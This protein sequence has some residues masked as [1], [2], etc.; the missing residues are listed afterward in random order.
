MSDVETVTL[1]GEV[2]P[3][4][5]VSRSRRA[6]LAGSA[7]GVG[8]LLNG[9]VKASPALALSSPAAS[10]GAPVTIVSAS[11]SAQELDCRGGIVAYD[12]TET[13]NCTYS[14]SGAVAGVECLITLTRWSD[15]VST[16]IF[17]SNL[18]WANGLQPFFAA[19]A[20][21]CDVIVFRSTDGGVRWQAMPALTNAVPAAAPPPPPVVPGAPT[22][23]AAAAGDGIVA[24]T[25][26]PP[27]SG[28][29]VTSYN[30][31]RGTA[32]G[33]ETL[34]SSAGNATSYTDTTVTNGVTYYYKV[35]ATNAAGE[36]SPSTSA[37]ASPTAVAGTRSLTLP[38][39]AG[40]YAVTPDAASNRISTDIDLRSKL[41]LPTSPPAAV[42]AIVGKWG[43]L[44]SQQQ[45]LMFVDTNGRLNAAT[46]INEQFVI[47]T[48]SVPLGSAATSPLWVRAT[49][50]PNTPTG[51]WTIRFY[52]APDSANSPGP[53]SLLGNDVVSTSGGGAILATGGIDV[54]VG[55][56][57]FGTINNLKGNIHR[58]QIR[59]GVDGPTV[60]DAD[61]TVP[62]GGATTFAGQTGE[63]WTVKGSA[64]I[65]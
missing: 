53:W 35:T 18:L 64:A 29:S 50:Q 23:L 20:G 25:W 5:Q 41:R 62:P 59:N 27:S 49:I 14:M 58:V 46:R 40:S 45:F 19:K 55:S 1:E 63:T 15:G 28:G 61:F 10:P 48:S 44:A 54:E 7:V 56:T 22:N 37:P 12:V 51:G 13:A 36:G 31:Y 2:A 65:A 26:A 9:I 43:N 47:A 21:R 42:G 32:A 52:T 24:M 16:P 11:G 33:Q 17:P 57:S 30:V 60:I 38:G 4:Q 39:T 8:A 3:A 34:L 6:I